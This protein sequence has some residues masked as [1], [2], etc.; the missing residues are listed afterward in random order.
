[1]DE[2]EHA[3]EV[4]QSMANAVAFERATTSYSSHVDSIARALME[5]IDNPPVDEA[6]ESEDENSDEMMET[7]SQRAFRYGN[8]ELC[9]VSDPEAWMVTHL[10][11]SRWRRTKQHSQIAEQFQKG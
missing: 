5:N 2:V 1:M 7:E 6:G 10:T 4:G 9:E 3:V 8:C 11:L